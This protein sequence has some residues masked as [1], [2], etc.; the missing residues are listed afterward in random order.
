MC[1]TCQRLDRSHYFDRQVVTL[2]DEVSEKD[3]LATGKCCPWS[4]VPGPWSQV[5]GPRP[6]AP[7]LPQLTTTIRG[8]LAAWPLPW[9]LAAWPDSTGCAEDH[10]C[11]RHA[12][13]QDDQ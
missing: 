13:G 11:C 1:A 8:C 4:L 3:V 12:G 7:G 10:P 5:P 9:L 6:Q 2:T